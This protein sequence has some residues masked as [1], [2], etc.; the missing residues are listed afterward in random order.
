MLF[1]YTDNRLKT[2][3]KYDKTKQILILIE[4]NLI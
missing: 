1:W 2:T 3:G 4:F